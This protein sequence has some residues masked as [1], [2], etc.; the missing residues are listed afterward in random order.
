MSAKVG[1]LELVSESVFTD[2]A[3]G[4]VALLGKAGNI[5]AVGI[6]FASAVVRLFLG[7]YAACAAALNLGAFPKVGLSTGAFTSTATEEDVVFVAVALIDAVKAVGSEVERKAAARSANERPP[8]PPKARVGGAD[9]VRNG[10][11]CVG[12]DAEFIL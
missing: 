4:A 12:N 6:T 10:A 2:R 3:V 11:D 7:T 5:S 1:F 8:A 9:C